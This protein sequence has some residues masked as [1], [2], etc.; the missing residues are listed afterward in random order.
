L[1][2]TSDQIL[3]LERVFALRSTFNIAAVNMSLGGGRY[4]D[5]ASCDAANVARKAAIDN[6]RSVNIATVISSG[7]DSFADSM[8]APGCI[9]SAVSVGS[10]DDGGS[11]MLDAVSSFSNSSFSILAGRWTNS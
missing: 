5:Q 7:N 3:G 11:V 9:S 2:F 8:G 10:T 1:S 4:F 6:L